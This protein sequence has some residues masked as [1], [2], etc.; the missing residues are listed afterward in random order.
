MVKS[1]AEIQREYRQRLKADP[2][3]YTEYL[4]KARERKKKNFI[5]VARLSRSEKKRRIERNVN[6]SRRHRLKQQINRRNTAEDVTSGYETAS[7]TGTSNEGR[8]IVKF[9][10]RQN[11]PKMRISNQLKQKSSD[12]K[13]L[14]IQ[15]DNL[16][17]KY[18]NA[19]R[20]LQ[21]IK[22][23][24][25]LTEKQHSI[26][27]SELTASPR[28]ET[29][30]LLSE[31]NI[32]QSK[33]SKVRKRLLLG[34][35]M[36]KQ[37][38]TQRRGLKR[39]HLGSLRG[40][41]GGKILQK[42]RLVST[43]SSNTGLGRNKLAKARE[44]ISIEKIRRSREVQKHRNSV[45]NF[46]LRDDNSRANPGKTDKRK[47]C[48][49]VIQTKTLTD[50]LKNL[51]QK[52]LSENPETKIS[53]ASF[54]RIRPSYIRPTA[55]ISRSS[56]LCTRH[57]NMALCLQALKRS[58]VGVTL[59]SNPEEFVSDETKIQEVLANVPNE[60]KIG[61][62]KRVPIEEK[63][64]KK[65]ITKIES[66]MKPDEF[67]SLLD[68]GIPEFPSHVFRVKRQYNE[69]QNLKKALPKNAVIVHM[70][71]A[72]NYMCK[73]L[74][75]VQSAYWT[76]ASVTL[77][78]VVVYY[79]DENS[80]LQHKSMVI[81]SDELGHNSSAVITFID[82]IMK[83]VSKI[84]PDLAIVHYWTDS[85]TSQYRNK[86]IFDLVS[87]HTDIYG[88]RAVWNYFEAGH[89]KGPCD[90][91]GGTTKRMADE[92]V[93]SGK[94]VIQDAR[95]FFA[96]SQSSFCSMS[97]VKFV[98][99]PSSD[100][101]ETALK[102]KSKSL[103]PVKGTL[104]IHAVVGREK[105][106]ILV[107]DVSCYCQNC[108]DEK[109]C[110]DYWTEAHVREKMVTKDTCE[111]RDTDIDEM[112]SKSHRDDNMA[113]N[114]SDKT[115]YLP[116]EFVAARYGKGWYVGKILQVDEEDQDV[117]IT[118]LQTEKGL[119]QWPSQEDI[120][121]VSMKNIIC[122]VPDLIPTGKSQ[123]MFKIPEKTKDEIKALFGEN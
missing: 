20:S 69:I 66:K 31:S 99:I 46:L 103:Q 15:Y 23:S 18:R 101:Q 93:R 63:G 77:H 104:K 3:A 114:G 70:D 68:H 120:I 17:S 80:D 71:F 117:E 74:E 44:G 22:K 6:Y 43:L 34:S 62:W 97:N 73:S 24:K 38:Q 90:G 121:W 41:I 59:P 76:Q 94:T 40:L 27:L 14:Q 32:P 10:N 39:S 115:L 47:Y 65:V 105:G 123:R 5:P 113:D 13:Q 75:E 106:S 79:S 11:G 54:C 111:Q 86:V 95:D 36:L 26:S 122:K 29:K 21:R 61:Q 87:N 37:V 30:Q 96:W 108:I 98:F 85:P 92:S 51:H 53:L 35:V 112:A 118:F 67:I 45:L 49:K 78:P 1:R 4:A 116:E 28:T 84:A 8:L 58:A 7:S 2:E 110:D 72:E 100:V 57:Q 88:V 91:L 16:N 109:Y 19:M 33:I 48:G 25:R 9:P 82:R 83:E 12:L 60:I 102:L 55:F 56:C 42:Y 64:K 50:Y 52:Y 89:G 119:F 81:V 107:A